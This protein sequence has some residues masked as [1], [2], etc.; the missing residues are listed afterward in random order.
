V[1][2]TSRYNLRPVTPRHY[3]SSPERIRERHHT[4]ATIA[5]AAAIFAARDLAKFKDPR[6]PTA[7]RAIEEA[8]SKARYLID[9]IERK[10]L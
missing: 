7:A 1:S 5:I 4:P 2:A 8:I 9:I 3:P 10:F 6:E